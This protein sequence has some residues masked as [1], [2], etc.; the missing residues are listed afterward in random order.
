MIEYL[1]S[2]KRQIINLLNNKLL[3]KIKIY[4]MI[5]IINYIYMMDSQ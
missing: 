2:I 3:I 1:T 5:Y 4:N